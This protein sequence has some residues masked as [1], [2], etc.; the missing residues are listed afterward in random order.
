LYKVVV[1]SNNYTKW[2]TVMAHSLG[3]LRLIVVLYG[4]YETSY[5]ILML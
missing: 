4:N 3:I 1:L 5:V 2:R